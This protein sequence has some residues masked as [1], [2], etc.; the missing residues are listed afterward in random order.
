MKKM[1]NGINGW[2]LRVTAVAGVLVL[3]GVIINYWVF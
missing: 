2:I 3:G 1:M